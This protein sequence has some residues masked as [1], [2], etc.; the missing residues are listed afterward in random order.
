MT[1]S[2]IGERQMLPMQTNRI[3]VAPEWVGEVAIGTA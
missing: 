3:D 2:A 1:A